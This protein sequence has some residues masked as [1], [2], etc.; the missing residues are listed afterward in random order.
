MAIVGIRSIIYGV[1]DLEASVR[2]Y[3]DFGL[4]LAREGADGADF[5]LPDGS[6]VLVRKADDP[7]LPPA[8]EQGSGVRRVVWAVDSAQSLAALERD[9][10]TDRLV[11]RIG[12]DTLYFND[13]VGLP[14]GLTVAQPKPVHSPPELTNAPGRVERWNRHRKWYEKAEPKLMQH[15]VFCHDNV[16]RAAAFYV[17]RLGFRIS[18]IQQDAGFFLRAGGRNEHHNIFWQPGKQLGFRHVAFGVENIDELM[19]GASEMQRRGWPSAL[20]LGRHRISSTHFYY[21][22]SPCGGE[23]E[24]STDTDYLDDDWKPR[25]WG[26]TFGH[27]YWASRPPEKMA[28]VE[29]RLAS[30]SDLAL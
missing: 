14:S 4:P 1:H 18:D 3:R 16:R 29:V 2:F 5:V 6:T 25:I 22:K 8:F 28:P 23:T 21:I 27:I 24:Y 7:T 9:L 17:K 30:A 26:R 12:D 19:V 13:D 20:G 10:K 15:V 11:Q